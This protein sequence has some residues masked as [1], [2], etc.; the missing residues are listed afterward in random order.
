M[1]V[2]AGLDA[3]RFKMRDQLRDLFRILVFVG[4]VQN[5]VFAVHDIR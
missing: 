5:A 4:G 1:D 3:N 2:M